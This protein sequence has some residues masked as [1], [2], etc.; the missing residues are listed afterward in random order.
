MSAL[1]EQR[2]YE[3][4]A[5]C[6]RLKAERAGLLEALRIAEPYVRAAGVLVHVGDDLA[7]VQAAIAKAEGRQ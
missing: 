5:E 6:E 2:L 1:V 3:K 4:H 7:Q